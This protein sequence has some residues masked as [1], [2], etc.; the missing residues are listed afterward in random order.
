HA[1]DIPAQKSGA[2]GVPVPDSVPP[3]N[4]A[5]VEVPVAKKSAAAV[6][7]PA[8]EEG[9]KAAEESAETPVVLPAENDAASEIPAEESG[10][11]GAPAESASLPEADAR[12]V[13]AGDEGEIPLE[14]ESDAAPLGEVAP[15]PVPDDGNA[16]NENPAADGGFFDEGA[17]SPSEMPEILLDGGDAGVSGSDSWCFFASRRF[18]CRIGFFLLD[19]K[20]W[21]QRKFCR[22]RSATTKARWQIPVI[23]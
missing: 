6:V 17:E 20:P 9:V 19:F 16:E 13:P 12:I 3:E 1:A 5:E 7:P 21:T 2:S 4:V 14:E 11:G 23:C 22:K 8:L 15:P 10:A 18:F